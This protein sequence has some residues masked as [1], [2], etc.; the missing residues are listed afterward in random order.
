MFKKFIFKHETCLSY[1]L[2]SIQL[3]MLRLYMFLPDIPK[4]MSITRTSYPEFNKLLLFI[5]VFDRCLGVLSQWPLVLKFV[6][7]ESV[8]YL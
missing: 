4:L 8:S 5:L 2:S 6:F 3:S 7:I 1:I